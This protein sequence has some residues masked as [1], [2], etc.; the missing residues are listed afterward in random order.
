MSIP[1]GGLPLRLLRVAT[2][3]A[4][5]IQAGLSARGFADVRPAHAFAFQR[6][7]EGGATVV[8]LAG[9]LGITKQAASQLVEQLVQR[10]YVW[11]DLNP[12]DGRAWLLGLTPRGEECAKAA[13]AAAADVTKRWRKQLDRAGWAALESALNSLATPGLVRLTW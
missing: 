3:V 11:R 7:G 13:R 6:L 2:Q 12:A 4:D 8:D 9:H 10:D 1:D 5:D